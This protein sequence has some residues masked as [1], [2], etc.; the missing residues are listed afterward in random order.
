[1][2][3]ISE[4]LAGRIGILHLTPFSLRER[5]E[6]SFT[7]H[8]L[9]TDFILQRKTVVQITCTFRFMEHHSGRFIP[10]VCV[11]TIQSQDFYGS[12]VKTYIERDVKALL[13]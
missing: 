7:S 1:M 5:F 6:D 10:E 12:Y 3:N 4:S 8:L 2:E 11:S 9:L 13:K